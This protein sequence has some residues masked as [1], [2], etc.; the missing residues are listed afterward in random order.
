MVD[1]TADLE[2][3]ARQLGIKDGPQMSRFLL[4]VGNECFEGREVSSFQVLSARAAELVSMFLAQ[5]RK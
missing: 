5:D 3:A 1:G 4:W 2:A